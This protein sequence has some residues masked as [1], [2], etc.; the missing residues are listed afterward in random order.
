MTEGSAPVVNAT[1]EAPGETAT[2]RDQMIAAA[3]TALAGEPSEE[4][5]QTGAET[6]EKPAWS[7]EDLLARYEAD[8]EFKKAVD[9]GLV[10]PKANALFQRQRDKEAKRTRQQELRDAVADPTKAVRAAREELAQLEAEDDAETNKAR[11]NRETFDKVGRPLLE[12]LNADPDLA[13]HYA[14]FYKREGADKINGKIK[15]DAIAAVRWIDKEVHRL[16]AKAEGKKSSSSEAEARATDQVNR[17]LVDLPS[18]LVG[19]GAPTAVFRNQREVERAYN[20]NRI[21]IDQMERLLP[22][23]PY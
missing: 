23:L 18:P 11:G 4:A 17:L 9:K 12:A 1:P 8:A 13:P 15:E 6:P 19:T 16:Y 5:P 3:D 10:D 2:L 21:T 7:L 20:A 14:D 22:T